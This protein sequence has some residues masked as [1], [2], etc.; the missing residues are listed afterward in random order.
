MRRPSGV[1]AGGAVELPETDLLVFLDADNGVTTTV[2]DE[3]TDWAD[4]G[5]GSGPYDFEQTDANEYCDFESAGGP[6]GGAALVFGSE[7]AG[8]DGH[9]TRTSAGAIRATAGATTFYLICNTATLSGGTQILLDFESPRVIL[10]GD[11]SGSVAFWDTGA[12]ATR[13]IAAPTLGWQCLTWVFDAPTGT[14][15]RGRS[16]LGSGTWTANQA[17]DGT[18]QTIGHLYTGSGSN[19]FDGR[20]AAVLIYDDAH[21]ATQ[22]AAVWDYLAGRFPSAG[23]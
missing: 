5:L 2:S 3:V 8:G 22:R 10:Y 14:V 15:Y 9:V 12:S 1:V 11:Q 18:R 16:S 6:D 7:S 20:M 17:L 23:L 19:A 4:Q 21:D 13:S